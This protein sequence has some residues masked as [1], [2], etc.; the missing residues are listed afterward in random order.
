[1][2]EELAIMERT[3]GLEIALSAT[4]GSLANAFYR[5]DISFQLGRLTQ[6]NQEAVSVRDAT[7]SPMLNPRVKAEEPCE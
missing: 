1:M 3:V 4:N 7:S 2:Y 5:E 6:V